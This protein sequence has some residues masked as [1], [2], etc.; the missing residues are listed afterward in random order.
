MD[1]NVEKSKNTAPQKN[2]TSFLNRIFGS[3]TDQVNAI[4][5]LKDQHREV[6]ELFA[7]IETAGT[8]AYKSKTGM[9]QK[10]CSKLVLHTKLEEKFLYPLVKTL[11]AKI[12]WEAEEEHSAVSMIIAKLRGVESGHDAFAAR[13]KVLRELVEHHIDEE[14][15]DMF[16]LINKEVDDERLRAIGA[17]MEAF[18]TKLMSSNGRAKPQRKT[19]AAAKMKR[20]MPVNHKGRAAKKQT[21]K[22]ASM[23]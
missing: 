7:T 9:A 19:K 11:D 5:F 6:K 18:A 12:F 22:R 2:S 21:A 17:K 1:M 4:D 13:L 14:E 20:A 10:I 15:R 16:P 3:T 23:H 8:T